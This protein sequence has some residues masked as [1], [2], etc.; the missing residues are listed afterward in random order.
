VPSG[1]GQ[2]KLPL[3]IGEATERV[4][5]AVEATR[6]LAFPFLPTARAEG[7]LHANADLDEAIR[8]MQAY[9]KAGADVLITRGDIYV[10]SPPYLRG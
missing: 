8:R 10:T 5:A 6:K 4:A 2:D 9:E 3:H 1:P 7:F